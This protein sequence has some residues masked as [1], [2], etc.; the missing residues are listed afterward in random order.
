MGRGHAAAVSSVW[1][2]Q[3][4]LNTPPPPNPHLLPC[5]N[6]DRHLSKR[7]AA[8]QLVRNAAIIIVACKSL[9][10]LLAAQRIEDQ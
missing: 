5:T 4:Q 8:Q 1:I 2:C 10:D 7:T 6:K 3:T 9:G